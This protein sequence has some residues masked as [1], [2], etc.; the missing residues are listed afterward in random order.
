MLFWDDG[1]FKPNYFVSIDIEKKIKVYTLMK[2]QV[3]SFRS[4]DHLKAIAKL[5]GGQSNYEYAES[6]QILRW[7]E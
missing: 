6:F 1:N 5:R 3:R 2:S 4:P 7:V